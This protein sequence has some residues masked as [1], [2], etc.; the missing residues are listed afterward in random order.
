MSATEMLPYRLNSVTVFIT[1][2]LSWMMDKFISFIFLMN[3]N[4]NVQENID[5]L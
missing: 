2:F 3:L 1:C 4:W 5:Y